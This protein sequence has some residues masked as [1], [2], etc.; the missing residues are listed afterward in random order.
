MEGTVATCFFCGGAAD[1]GSRLEI[2]TS[3]YALCKDD[4]AVLTQHADLIWQWLR[5]RMGLKRVHREG[6]CPCGAKV[7]PDDAN[8]ARLRIGSLHVTLC[9]REA[10][11]VKKSLQRLAGFAR[12]VGLRGLIQMGKTMFGV[13]PRD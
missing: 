2:G 7:A 5:A 10:V 8:A 3:T 6:E 9:A 4:T 1:A 11:L 12:A 13:A